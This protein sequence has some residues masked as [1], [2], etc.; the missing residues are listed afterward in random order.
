M[1]VSEKTDIYKDVKHLIELKNS[2]FNHVHWQLDVLWDLP[3]YQRY[4]NFDKWAKE[5][6]EGITKLIKYWIKKWKKRE[7][8]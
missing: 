5:Y 7:K 4:K 8:S 6:N 3:P 2:Q 1:A